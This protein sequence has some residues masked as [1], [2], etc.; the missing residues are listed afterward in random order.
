V[1]RTARTHTKGQG[2]RELL[3]ARTR[4][5]RESSPGHQLAELPTLI[6]EEDLA[7]LRHDIAPVSPFYIH[8][9]ALFLTNADLLAAYPSMSQLLFGWPDLSLG[10]LD[11][12]MRRM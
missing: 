7:V 12:Q 3:E 4:R 1:G 6:S 11:F 2:R 8:L 9:S 10:L 5:F